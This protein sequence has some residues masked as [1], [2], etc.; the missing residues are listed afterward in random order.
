MGDSR[1]KS[2]GEIVLSRNDSR[3]NPI[4]DTKT[5]VEIDQTENQGDPRN[6]QLVSAKTK[7]RQHKNGCCPKR[8]F[9]IENRF[10]FCQSKSCSGQRRHPRLLLHNKFLTPKMIL[11]NQ[12]Q[13]HCEHR[14]TVHHPQNLQKA[15]WLVFKTE[16]V[17]WAGE[18]G[19][20]DGFFPASP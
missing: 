6:R 3:N 18:G 4:P 10:P 11:E 17:R 2:R 9:W 16:R 20:W 13:Y 15:S 19:T 5:K 1:L 8:G 7:T 12:T 14:N